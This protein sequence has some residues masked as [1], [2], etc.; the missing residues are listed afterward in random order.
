MFFVLLLKLLI[1]FLLLMLSPE[2]TIDFVRKFQS[3][4]AASLHLRRFARLG[5]VRYLVTSHDLQT[6]YLKSF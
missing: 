1:M 4:R 3:L 6:I 2:N 5:S